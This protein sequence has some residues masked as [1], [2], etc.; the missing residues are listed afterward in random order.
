MPTSLTPFAV[1]VSDEL[2]AENIF[3]M[4]LRLKE[5]DRNE[6]LSR[7]WRSYA[8]KSPLPVKLK[9]HEIEV[10][11]LLADGCDETEIARQLNISVKT[12]QQ[13]KQS[14]R[15][16]LKVDNMILLIRYA[17]ETGLVAPQFGARPRAK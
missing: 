5:K 7:L 2:V 9:P 4:I 3:Q 17:I 8:R 13:R 6:L 1:R 16:R 14:A 12:V 11:R 10:V 15:R